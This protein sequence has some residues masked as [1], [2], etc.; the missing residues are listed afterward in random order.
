MLFKLWVDDE[1][2]M[3]DG[4]DCW[5]H[6]YDEAVNAINTQFSPALYSL[7]IDFDHDLGLGRNGYDFAKWLL[8][9]DYRGQFSIHSMNPIGAANIRQLLTHYGWKETNRKFYV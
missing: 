3:P 7:F 6:T 1:R 8:E 9:N 4:Y 2:Q 5:A